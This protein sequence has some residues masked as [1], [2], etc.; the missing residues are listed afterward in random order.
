M[1]SAPES[2]V[3]FPGKVVNL[4]NGLYSMIE[5]GLVAC[6]GGFGA[7]GGCSSSSNSG[8]LTYMPEGDTSSNAIVKNLAI[9]LTSGR[10][11]QERQT[12]I[13]FRQCL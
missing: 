2:Q 4:L 11:S 3:M 12:E 8:R 13:Q 1:L 6:K 9:L 10:L 5:Y 7:V